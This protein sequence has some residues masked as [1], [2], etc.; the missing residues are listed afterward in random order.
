M[1]PGKVHVLSGD[2]NLI[3]EVTRHESSVSSQRCVYVPYH[4]TFTAQ[5]AT[6]P[7]A[8]RGYVAV[9][10]VSKL[11][12]FLSDRCAGIIYTSLCM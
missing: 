8:R 4:V 6:G 2:K 7:V 11:K 3:H 5:S 9:F 12:A 10:S 1:L